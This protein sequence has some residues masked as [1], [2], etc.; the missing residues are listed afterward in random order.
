M[1]QIVWANQVLCDTTDVKR[2]ITTL[3]VVLQ[4][5]KDA[6]TLETSIKNKI[7]DAKDFIRQDILKKVK[8]R[9]PERIDNWLTMKRSE[10]EEWRMTMARNA[11][12][13]NTTIASLNSGY[14]GWNGEFINLEDQAIGFGL[15]TFW[16]DGIPVNGTKAD[17]ATLVGQALNGAM[18]IETTTN[19]MFINHSID[20]LLVQWDIH[21]SKDAI[22]RIIGASELKIC[23][24]TMT[25]ILMAGDG[26]FS[27]KDQDEAS[28]EFLRKQIKDWRCEQKEQF[29]TGFSL[30]D[31]D[32][33]G[34]GLINDW[35]RGITGGRRVLFG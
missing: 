27:N 29:E 1:P 25:I 7:E 23:C 11:Q 15:N 35:E 22:D 19:R 31:F 12:I 9:I 5:N 30:I 18:L 13:N 26:M 16:N 24:V 33:M 34:D 17:N 28:R 10:Y 21:S 2:R 3:E 20:P 32:I 8:N 4:T 14:L 6:G